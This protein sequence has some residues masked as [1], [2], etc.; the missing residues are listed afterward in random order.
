M[1]ERMGRKKR[2]RRTEEP[3]KTTWVYDDELGWI[4]V[5]LFLEKIRKI[6]QELNAC[7]KKTG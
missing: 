5:N 2:D 6:E 4:N 7:L 3:V 1:K